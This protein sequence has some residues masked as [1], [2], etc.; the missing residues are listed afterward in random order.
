MEN[1]TREVKIVL[2]HFPSYLVHLYPL[3][4]YGTNT[5]T[6]T[7][8]LS[9]SASN[10]TSSLWPIHHYHH[11]I[12]VATATTT[13]TSTSITLPPPPQSPHHHAHITIPNLVYGHSRLTPL[14]VIVPFLFFPPPISQS[15][16]YLGLGK[17]IDLKCTTY[18]TK[19]F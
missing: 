18:F 7:T 2:Q 9:P 12:F 19:H 16:T 8:L 5:S 4:L 1:K 17:W 15:W 11:N 6:T 10:A 14:F 13:T 3:L